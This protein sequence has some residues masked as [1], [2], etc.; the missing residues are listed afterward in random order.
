MPTDQSPTT[1][2]A[3]QAAT[4]NLTDAADRVA[5][6]TLDA[7]NR[8]THVNVAA[9]RMLGLGPFEVLGRHISDFIDNDR[10]LAMVGHHGSISEGSVSLRGLDLWASLIPLCRDHG[11]MM[12]VLAPEPRQEQWEHHEPLKEE[13]SSLL[14][15]SYDGIVVADKDCIRKV[16]ASFGRITGLPPSFLINKKIKELDTD[17]HVCLAAVQEVIRL[18]RHHQKTITLQRRIKTGNEIFL[19]CSPVMNRHGRVDRVVLNVRDITE[20]K[21]LESQIKKLSGLRRDR[22]GRGKQPDA[23]K[24]IVAESPAMQLLLQVVLRVSQV[25]STVLL[26]GE[27][28]VGK[29]VIAGLIHRLSPR[30]EGPFISV[31]CGAVPENLLESEFFGYEKGAFTSASRS[32]KPG[33]FEQANGGTFLLDEIGELPL[34]LQ[35]KLLKVIQDQHCRRL[36]GQRNIRLDIRF[37]AATNRD[38]RRMVAEGKF[39]EDLFYR[40]YVVPIEIA[41]LRER[42]ED[43]LPL[44]LMFLK[45][46]ISDKYDVSRTL[47]HE[48]MTILESY[49]WPG[50]VRELQNVIE[51]MV[52]TADSEVLQPRHLPDSVYQKAAQKG[53]G[54]WVGGSL[55][56]R[57]ARDELERQLI[58]KALSKTGNTRNAAKLLGVDHSTVVRKAQ[59]LGLNL[60][61]GTVGAP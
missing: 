36:G 51:R 29:D 27:S 33:L 10:L 1:P 42:R 19:T 25:N 54:V 49:D 9:Q 14:E 60:K 47:S 17:R 41:P 5:I 13:L 31:N 61:G 23:L 43:I 39:R 28:G 53:L 20:L 8:V 18:T 48:L 40:L 56:L 4:T 30:S 59:K 45:E 12:V 58:L 50:N 24:E 35:V 26:T 3:A 32:G 38:M 44:A 21:G 6:I 52:V 57:Q 11:G 55:N 34:N 46:L 37:I 16:N 15:N 7:Q 22:D 2:W